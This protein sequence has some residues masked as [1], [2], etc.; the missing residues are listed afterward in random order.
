MLIDGKEISK[1]VYKDIVNE[2]D[3]ITKKIQRPP[4]LNIILIG[5][6]PSSLTYVNNKLKKCKEIGISGNLI[7]KPKNIDEQ[8]VISIINELNQ[9]EKVDGI[10]LQ[11]PI[12]NHL[13]ER[14]L[15]EKI[16]PLKDVDGLTATN[17][18]LLSI[19]KPRFIPA[20]AYGIMEILKNEN[21]TSEG[22]NIVVIGRSNIVGKP[23]VAL[24][25][26]KDEN[27]TVTVCH[28][29]TINLKQ[30]T[31]NADVII[32]AVGKPNILDGSMIKEGAIVIDVGINRIEN[33]ENSKGFSIVGDVDFNSI[34]KKAS[35]ITPVPGGVGPM[36]I[37]M[38]MKNV[39]EAAKLNI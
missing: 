19:G 15:I 23:M 16:S 34:L 10:I 12:P 5:D 8:S 30:H 18:G 7:K 26:G 4:S 25:S 11:L 35:S 21:I 33:K 36:T 3:V 9:D 38:L 6:N 24:L 27:A 17:I 13:N 2:I 20:T 28:S 22:K 1:L 31:L 14:I 32:V 39:C 29:K 37:A